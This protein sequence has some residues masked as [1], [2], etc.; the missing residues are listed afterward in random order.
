MFLAREILVEKWKWE[1]G[2]EKGKN[3]G[4]NFHAELPAPIWGLTGRVT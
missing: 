4:K 2:W 1:R 3:S